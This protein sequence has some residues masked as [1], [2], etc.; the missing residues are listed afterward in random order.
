[1]K[2]VIIGAIA[3]L[4]LSAGSARVGKA[5]EGEKHKQA[6]AECP[7]RMEGVKA[8]VEETS[9]GV[10]ITLTAEDAETAVRLRKAVK[11]LFAVKRHHRG[12]KKCGHCEKSEGAGHEKCRK[13][14]EKDKAE[15]KEMKYACPMG[16]HESDKPGDCP[17]CGM[18]M[19]KKSAKKNKG[20]TSPKAE[21]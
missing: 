8:S 10:V 21:K 20:F 11:K 12:G 6:K 13:H 2:K 17:K 5:C 15:K 1:M 4:A 3:V 16:C 7:M 14:G 18:K 19:I 9:G